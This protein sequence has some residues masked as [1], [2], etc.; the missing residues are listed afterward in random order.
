MATSGRNSPL[1]GR[2]LTGQVIATFYAGRPTVLEGTLNA[3]VELS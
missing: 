2:K 3:P 1:R